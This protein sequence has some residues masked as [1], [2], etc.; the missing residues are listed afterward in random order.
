M[1]I[2]CC[3]EHEGGRSKWVPVSFE[4]DVGKTVTLQNKKDF[5][6]EYRKILIQDC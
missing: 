5:S 6:G 2:C 3:T 1:N 4:I